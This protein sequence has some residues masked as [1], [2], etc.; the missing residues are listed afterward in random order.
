MNESFGS[1]FRIFANVISRVCRLMNQFFFSF[2]WCMEA[3]RERQI[4]R[5]LSIPISINHSKALRGG[6]LLAL[7]L[8]FGAESFLAAEILN[9]VL[10]P[11]PSAFVLASARLLQQVLLKANSSI[12]AIKSTRVECNEKSHKYFINFPP[13]ASLSFKKFANKL[14]RESRSRGSHYADA[15]GFFVWPDFQSP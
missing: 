4:W 11:I 14:K 8:A 3:R 9:I 15:F 10:V 13:F 5:H 7:V 6:K 2:F 1:R 12:S